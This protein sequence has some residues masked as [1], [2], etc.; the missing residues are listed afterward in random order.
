MAAAARRAG[1]RL[2]LGRLVAAASYGLDASVSRDG[3]IAF[4]A[5]EP[6]HPA[7]VYWLPS[8]TAKPERLTGFNAHIAA[9]ELGKTEAIEWDGPDGFRMDGVVTYP[10]G[11]QTGR[12]YPLVLMIHG[13]P[14]ATS[15]AAFSPRVQL[16][17]AQGW[18]VFEPNYRGSDNR[19]TKF[20]TAR[21]GAVL[22]VSAA[23][24]SPTDPVHQRDID[25]RWVEWFKTRFDSAP[26]TLPSGR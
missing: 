12:K 15:K 21:A 24:H 18:I 3:R 13:G 9:L 4:V 23:G 17:A 8:V 19:G 25:R 26:T 14:R 22:R 20:M 6:Q 16:L 5:S 10:P 7:E 11:F 2:D 1:A